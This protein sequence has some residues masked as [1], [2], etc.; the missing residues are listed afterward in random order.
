MARA[1]RLARTVRRPTS[2]NPPVGALIVRNGTVV[3]EGYHKGA[4]HPHA[5]VVALSQ[6][7][8]KA[9]DA[10]LYVTLEPC[11]HYGRTPPCTD[12]IIRA[13]ISKVVVATID[14]NPIVNGKGVQILQQAGLTVLTGVLEKEATYLLA[15]FFKFITKKIPFAILK[16]AM[17][18]DG[19]IATASGQSRWIT[20]R[21]AQKWVHR[22]RRQSDAILVGVGTILADDPE[23]TVR[24]VPSYGYQPLRIV[25][26]SLART[27]P[28]AK[29]ITAKGGKTIIA[30]TAAAPKE[31][32]EALERA[33]AEVWQL[34]P[35]PDGRGVDLESLFRR[36][37]EQNV[38]NLLVEGGSELAGSLLMAGLVDRIAFFIA[39]LLVGGA[40]A[41][42]AIGGQGIGDLASAIFLKEP[43]FRKIGRDYL[44][45][46]DIGFPD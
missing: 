17:T 3:G 30:V 32:W 40:K 38:M 2:P 11:A 46:A 33:G 23:L 29:V 36:L 5:E 21:K 25:A 10:T 20:G 42:P 16:L 14:R 9:K 15:P 31:R 19:K 39:P 34:P 37:A 35:S 13:G 1:L 44:L 7:G 18:A 6:A 8:Q 41:I 45:L 12:A 26:D 24:L 4:G 22:L 27:P 43:T 28:S